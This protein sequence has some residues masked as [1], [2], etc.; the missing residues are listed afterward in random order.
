[1]PF[2]YHIDSFSIFKRCIAITGWAFCPSLKILKISLEFPSGHAYELDKIGLPSL[3]VANHFGS[4]AVSVRFDGQIIVS[5][6]HEDIFRAALIVQTTS[7]KTYRVD[8]IENRNPNSAFQVGTKFKKLIS[9]I[10]HIGQFLEVGSR[11]R[12]GIVRRE[13]MPSGWSYTGLDV[14]DGE[15]VDVV[16][17]AHELSSVLT[18]NKYDAVMS[19]SVLEHILMPWKFVVELNKVMNI[20]GIGYFT[21]H[22]SWPLHDAPWDFWRFSD[23]SWTA[24]LNSATGFEIIEVAMS[25]PAF[26]VAEFF[27]AATD[28]REQSSYL[29]SVVL[30]RKISE[31]NLNWPVT[32]SSILDNFYPK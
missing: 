26:T 28:F 20:G 3:D 2:H 8:K 10:N 18:N 6:P 31:T 29:S 1:M 13:I 11:A 5:E 17:D 24:L 21:T 16:G 12:S 27:H 32:S 30:F 4:D 9:E 19:F 25:E 22:Q 14:M 7:G 15:N 23:K